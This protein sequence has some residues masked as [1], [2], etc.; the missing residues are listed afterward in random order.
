VKEA[1]KNTTENATID[2]IPVLQLELVFS[3]G[4]MGISL[5]PLR[6][7]KLSWQPGLNVIVI[8]DPTVGKHMVPLSNVKHFRIA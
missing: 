8:D 6:G 4:A 5:Q 3:V 2:G 1:T 7:R